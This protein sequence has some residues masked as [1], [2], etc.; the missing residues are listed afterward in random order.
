MK[1]TNLEREGCSPVSSNCVIWQGPDIPCINLCKGD[2]V[3]DVVAK[4]ATELC[5]LID[6]FDIDQYDLAC[7]NVGNCGP[8]DF[9]ELI[10]LLI[11]RICALEGGIVPNPT[12]GT[13]GCPDCTVNIAECFYYRNPQGDTVTTM[14]LI[15]YVNAIG[16]RIC[17][18]SSS[19]NIINQVLENHDNRITALETAPP[20]TITLPQVTPVCVTS[21]P[22]IAQEMNVVLGALEIEFCELLGATGTAPELLAA[23]SRQCPNLNNSPQLSG[24][25]T[26]STIPGWEINVNSVAD[27]LTNIWLT[28]CDLRSGVLNIQSTCCPNNCD[29]VEVDIQAVLTD[30]NTLKLYFTGAVPVGFTECNSSGTTFTITD[31][32]GG[33]ITFVVPVIS[34]LNN[35]AGY[36]I[37]LT[38]TPINSGESL[39]IT[40]SAF[41]VTNGESQCQDV[42]SFI[43]NS[44]A[45]CPLIDLTASQNSIDYEYTWAAGA[46]SIDV[47]LWNQAQTMMLQSQIT[48]VPGVGTYSGTFS[49]LTTGTQYRI[50]VVITIGSNVTTCNFVPITTLPAAC[51][52]ATSLT[53]QIDTNP[54]P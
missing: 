18:I 9:Q 53:A 29:G 36:T 45:A 52:P 38:G 2:T 54:I 1:P 23:I 11:D 41:C 39:I 13:G 4:L 30:P 51:L 25:G 47:Q 16:N 33:S 19:I 20:P 42:L 46:A 35:L 8:K 48:G 37:D 10:Q 44:T 28:I 34:N 12:P 22:G 6:M 40:A 50:R 7:L 26:M 31:E 32:S 14:Q 17:S 21:Q 49:G 24:S 43:L 5:N 3:S 27:T 15:D